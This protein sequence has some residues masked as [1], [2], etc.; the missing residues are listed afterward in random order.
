MISSKREFE[1][2]ILN[3]LNNIVLL[4]ECGEGVKEAVVIEVNKIVDILE[5]E[6]LICKRIHK[7]SIP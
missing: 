5:K 3:P 1:D 2:K 6:G 4:V 7:N